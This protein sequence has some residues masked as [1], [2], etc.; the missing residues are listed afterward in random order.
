MRLVLDTNVI[1]AA[2][3]SRHSASKLLLR[4][5]DQG[6]ITPLCS[7]ALFLEYKAVLSREVVREVTRAYI[8]GC[9]CGDG[10][11]DGRDREA[12]SGLSALRPGSRSDLTTTQYTFATWRY[13]AKEA[14]KVIRYILLVII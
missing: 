12:E 3:R 6:L 14:L 11:A 13:H 9:G 5:A 8:G 4:F 2:F 1:V 7:T 10:R